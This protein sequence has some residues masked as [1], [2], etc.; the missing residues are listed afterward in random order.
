MK[1]IASMAARTACILLTLSTQAPAQSMGDPACDSLLL[2]SSWR[3]DNVKLFDGCSHAYIRDL[4]STGLLDGPQTLLTDADG[5]VLVISENNHRVVRFDKQ[6]LSVGT[7]MLGDDPGTAVV[8][9]APLQKPIGAVLDSQG[10]L[11]LSSFSENKV[12]RIDPTNW[13]VTGTVL[14]GNNGRIQGA[15]AG[16]A[17][18]PDGRLYV[19]GFDSNNVIA[20]NLQNSQISDA[21]A[22]G[23]GGLNAPRAVL[24]DG[25]G[26]LLVSGWRNNAIL[27]FEANGAE[28]GSLASVPRPAGMAMDGPEHLLVTSDTSN[29]VQRI[30]V[31]TGEAELL[32]GP[33][34][35]V[36]DG[37][38]YALRFH[39]GV[40]QIA[41]DQANTR[42]FWVLGVGRIEGASIQIDNAFTTANGAFGVDFDASEIE[43]LEWGTLSVEF[44]SCHSAQFSYQGDALLAG[45][46]F[47]SQNYPLGRL[48]TNLSGR[49]CDDAGFDQVETAAWMSGTWYGGP[50]HDG[51]GML[52]D[53]LNE[54][55]AVLAWYTYLPIE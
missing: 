35:G 21:V 4:D 53:V 25:Q 6:T 12:L 1:Q 10:Q 39:K 26:R 31:N 28:A 45:P 42:H 52:I 46:S 40:A 15:D 38:T 29:T 18:G 49:L 30:H 37:A 17:L 55:L 14:P 19:P 9:T 8:E 24:F 20:V 36:L 54:E 51:K 3:S 48:A 11:L 5:H 32:V 34:N 27:R 7:V 44:D 16:I 22:A 13:Q 47:G 2:V 23:T 50:A 33:G 43:L 41:V